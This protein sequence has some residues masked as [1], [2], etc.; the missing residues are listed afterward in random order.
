M[1]SGLA[2][3]IALLL[4][5]TA[6]TN[7]HVRARLTTSAMVAAAYAVVGAALERG[8]IGGGMQEQLR[9]IQPLLLAFAV[10]NSLVALAINPLRADR[11][12]DRFPTIVQD[13]IVIGL[14]GLAATLLLQERI[15]A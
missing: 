10:V 11:L 7:R 2:L 13:A 15:F 3:A 1:I 6:S 9:T 5:R 4:A 12:P 14:F 8:A